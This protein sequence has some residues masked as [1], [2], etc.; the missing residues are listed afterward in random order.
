[1]NECESEFECDFSMDPALSP[2][3]LGKSNYRQVYVIQIIQLHG[4][5]KNKN[6]EKSG[7]IQ[8]SG[9]SGLDKRTMVLV[10]VHKSSSVSKSLTISSCLKK[11]YLTVLLLY[12]VCN[13]IRIVPILL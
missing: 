4:H 7:K 9:K 11:K 12:T 10:P 1:M 2:T 8:I 3:Y 13:R 5:L 6:Q